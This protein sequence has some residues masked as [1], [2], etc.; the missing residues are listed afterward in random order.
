MRAHFLG[1]IEGST[2][3]PTPE[4]IP[5]TTGEHAGVIGAALL[6]LDRLD[7]TRSS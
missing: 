4:I 1:H 5:A 2:Y 6:A 3:R 7:A